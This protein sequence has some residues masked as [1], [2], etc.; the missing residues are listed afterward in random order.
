MNGRVRKEKSQE[1]RDERDEGE[2][3]SGERLG[4]MAA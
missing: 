4:V 1:W 3:E 2:E